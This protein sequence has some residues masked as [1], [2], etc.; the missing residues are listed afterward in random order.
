MNDQSLFIPIRK[1]AR[2]RACPSSRMGALALGT[3]ISLTLSGCSTT[4]ESFDCK[5][6]RGVGC[7]SISEVNRMV[8]QGHYPGSL[9][10]SDASW[11]QGKQ[12]KL[13]PFEA[14]LPSAPVISTAPL[15]VE[16]SGG[17]HSGNLSVQRM[18]EE[19]VRVWVA[20]YQDSQ[21][22]LHEGSVIHTVLKPG[23]WQ[24]ETPSQGIK[25][26]SGNETA[27]STLEERD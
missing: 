6:G 9:V 7:K 24:L 20:P 21:G 11:T 26:L 22:N 27:G 3:T 12:S 2:K 16:Y 15:P 18:P 1:S 23:R 19:Y 17:P 8:D 4:S 13:L 10:E 25:G 14:A 5:A